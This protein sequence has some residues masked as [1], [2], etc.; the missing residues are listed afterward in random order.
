MFMCRKCDYALNITTQAKPSAETVDVRVETP[1]QLVKLIKNSP[2]AK[3]DVAFDETTLVTYLDSKRMDAK[4][5]AKILVHYKTM[6]RPLSSVM[7]SC[8]SCGSMYDLAAGTVIYA[9]N[10][11]K[12]SVVF[13][14]DDAQLL[15]SDPTLP[16]TKD[17]TC[18]NDDCPSRVKED[19]QAQLEKE[20][21]FY[22]GS[23]SFALRYCCRL[24]QASWSV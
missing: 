9:L 15:L 13:D 24:C 17:Y 5:K 18:A 11:E 23:N 14:D 1:D 12:K 7:L 16:R 21:V 2:E 22:R 10:L 19:Q 6:S 4:L 8:T 3:A 20:A